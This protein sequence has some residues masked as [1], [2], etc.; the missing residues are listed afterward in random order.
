MKSSMT[1]RSSF[2]AMRSRS[3]RRCWRHRHAERIVDHRLHI[4]RRQA[5]LAMRL[6]HR[7]RP[8]A[9]LVHRERHQ[10]DAEL[11]GDALGERIGDRL[12]AAAAAGRHQRRQHR[13]DALPAVAGEHHL[14]RAAA[15]IL[16]RPETAP[17]P[18]ARARCRCWW[19]AAA[20]PAAH[21]ARSSPSRLFAISAACAGRIGKLNS[22]SMREPR[23]SPAEAMPPLSASPDNERAA[24]DL[25]DHEASPQQFAVDAACGGDRDVARIGELPLRRQPVAGF[26]R[27]LA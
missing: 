13:G 11:R 16:R 6:L 9:V 4:D 20:P 24:P 12:D 5:S 1:T 27:A 10:R 18:A 26:Q 14:S 3:A 25:A 23:G 21:R 2:S 17:R 22:R 8:H 15:T 19:T 7:V